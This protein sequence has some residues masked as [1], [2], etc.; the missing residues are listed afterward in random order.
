MLTVRTRLPAGRVGGYVALDLWVLFAPMQT[1]CNN[2]ED[3]PLT[4][5]S[6]PE[7]FLTEVL[8]ALLYLCGFCYHA[9]GVHP[10]CEL[11]VPVFVDNGPFSGVSGALCVLQMNKQLDCV[12]SLTLL[13]HLRPLLT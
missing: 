2:L 12:S 13:G 4:P 1:K 7:P 10:D 6:C 9:A 11:V 5:T 3:F 8:L